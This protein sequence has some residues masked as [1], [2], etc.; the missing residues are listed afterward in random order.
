VAEVDAG[1]LRQLDG[2]A[3]RASTTAHDLELLTGPEA[4]AFL[5]AAAAAAGGRLLS[6]RPGQVTHRLRQASSASYRTKIRWPDGNVSDET[7][8]ACTGEPPGGALVLGAGEDRVGVWRFPYDP[9]LPGLP[10]ACDERAVGAL[11]GDLGL[12]SDPVRLR[13]RAYRPLRRSVIEAVGSHG[14]LFLKAV[15]PDRVEALH[16]RHRLLVSSGLPAPQSLGWTPAGVLVL[17]ALPGRTLRQ[18]LMSRATPV[19]TGAELLSVLDRLPAPIADEDRRPSWLE[20][21]GHYAAVVAAVLP[22]HADRVT[23]LA[24]AISAEAGTGPA[25]PV[26]GDFYENQL[27]VDGGRV[28]GLLDIDTAGPGERLDDLACLLGHLSVLAELAPQRTSAIK[29]LGARYLRVFEQV[30]HPADLRYRVAA[31]VMSLATGPHRV[32]QR[33]WPRATR[34]RVDLAEQ[35]VDSARSVANAG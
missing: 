30:T 24:A 12:G 16:D 25:V 28:C 9:A 27:L 20:R 34:R 35:W 5:T 15:R 14:R 18:A 26:H 32:Q 19:P 22:E 10:T 7:L 6:W 13:V 29:G 21:V 4:G 31:V 23:G 17:Q 1:A 11:L 3:S 33:G 8:A 2:D